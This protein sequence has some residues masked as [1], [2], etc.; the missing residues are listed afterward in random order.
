MMLSH[1]LKC[2]LLASWWN[3]MFPCLLLT[4]LVNYS[5]KCL[6]CLAPTQ[7]TIVQRYSSGRTKT[8]HIMETLAA[9]RQDPLIAHMRTSPFSLSTDGSNDRHGS[10]KPFPIVITCALDNGDVKNHL[11]SLPTLKEDATG[12][13]IF[14]V[15][16]S[17][18][19]RYNIPWDNCVCFGSDNANVMVGKKN[20]VLGAHPGKAWKHFL[21]WLCVCHLIH[22][23]AEK[24]TKQ[25]PVSVENFFQDLYYYTDE[26]ET[27]GWVWEAAGWTGC[28][29][30]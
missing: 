21:Q 15:I 24:A 12:Q 9:D 29:S 30:T 11:L 4:M 25:L 3:T 14:K 7:E 27:S 23:A 5:N 26:L 1:V 18:L 28:S 2:F 19:S 20:G 6:M 22:L 10:D 17:Q 16:D 13:N 8:S